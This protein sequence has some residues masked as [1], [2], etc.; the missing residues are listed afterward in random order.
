MLLPRRTAWEPCSGP[1]ID[2]VT[3]QVDVPLNSSAEDSGVL[4]FAD[5]PATITEPL[6]TID[7]GS[8]TALAPT[9]ADVIVPAGDHVPFDTLG[10]N[11][12]AL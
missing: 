4:P 7:V 2:G 8:T 9:R 5:P 6:A 11:V 3:V 10:S 1:G 12:I